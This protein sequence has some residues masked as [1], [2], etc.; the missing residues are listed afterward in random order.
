MS[1]RTV[2]VDDFSPAVERILEDFA[3]EVEGDMRRAVQAAGRETVQLLR[4]TSPRESGAYAEGWRYR[5]EAGLGPLGYY[6]RV[7]NAAKPSLTHLLEYGHELWAHGADTGRAVP[8]SPHIEIAAD[9]AV[10]VLLRE[11]MRP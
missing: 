3:R 7:Y 8:G 6:V 9:T 4:E 10:Q 1:A 11:A 5:T 2:T